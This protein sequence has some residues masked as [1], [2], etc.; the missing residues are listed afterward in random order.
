M[1]KVELL[2][3]S[4]TNRS[5]F[6]FKILANRERLTY[7]II[8]RLIIRNISKTIIFLFYITII[9]PQISPFSCHKN[10]SLFNEFIL[11]IFNEFFKF[12]FNSLIVKNSIEKEKRKK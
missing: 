8:I 9:Q 11:Y 6:R 5:I 12:I 7:I 10:F 3:R 1:S 4:I 2:S